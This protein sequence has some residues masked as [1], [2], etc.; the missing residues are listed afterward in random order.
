M[1]PTSKFCIDYDVKQGLCRLVIKSATV[2][3]S[4]KYTVMAKNEHGSFQFNVAVIVGIDESDIDTK[5]E[6]VTTENDSSDFDTKVNQEEVLIKEAQSEMQI[7]SSEKLIEDQIIQQSTNE[8]LTNDECS[9][10][11]K[12]VVTSENILSTAPDA[13]EEALIDV[14]KTN[15][16]R[17]EATRTPEVGKKEVRENKE[18]KPWD[19][20][21]SS[22]EEKGSPPVLL[23]PP[24]P[25]YINIGETINLTLK[26]KGG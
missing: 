24:E 15:E 7:A 22:E 20:S 16:S 18:K 8:T 14:K 5:D 13:G 1:L 21:V 10:V 23:V 4:G 25:Q 19:D 12:D 2:D 3:D 6:K 9:R 26:A 17:D 11:T